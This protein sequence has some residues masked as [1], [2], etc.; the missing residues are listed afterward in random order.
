MELRH[1]RYFL[2]VADELNF[3]RAAAR[4]GIGQP[5]LSQ[6]VRDMEREL[7]V[8]LLQRR[9]YG[10]ELTE[11]GK[12]F[13]DKIR[14]VPEIVTQATEIARLVGAG[15]RGMI[16]VGFTGSTAFYP[17]VTSIIRTFRDQYPKVDLTLKEANSTGLIAAI[18]ERK[19]DIAFIRP[20]PAPIPALRVSVLASEPMVAVLPQAH[21][22]CRK[23]IKFKGY[24]SREL[25]SY[26][27]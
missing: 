18:L 25:Y 12:V 20:P 13:L 11:A 1:I 2:M 23:K 21:P 24:A 8:K 7:G 17:L 16:R 9:A 6:Q 10:V 26:T 4:I 15:D 19:L 14:C 5:P 3:T 22:L 27:S